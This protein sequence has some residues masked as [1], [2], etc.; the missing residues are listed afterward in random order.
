MRKDGAAAP[1]RRLSITNGAETRYN[2][3]P[4][5]MLTPEVLFER[6]WAAA[7]ISSALNRLQV[8]LA[9]SGRERL[10]TALKGFLTADE[11]H[12]Y[13]R[14]AEDLRMTEGAVKVAIHRMRRRFRALLRAEVAEIV[15]D[16]EDIDDEIRYLLSRI[17][18]V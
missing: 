4:V 16:E 6:R 11:S 7:L 10:F 1:G 5:D 12:G 14:V 3:E 13:A 2:L 17:G 9:A 15:S 18:A 8:E